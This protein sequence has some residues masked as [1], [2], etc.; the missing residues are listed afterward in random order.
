[1]PTLSIHGEILLEDIDG[2][3]MADLAHLEPFGM[4]NRRPNFVARGV[5]VRKTRIVKGNHLQMTLTGELSFHRLPLVWEID[6]LMWEGSWM[7]YFIPIGTSGTGVELFNKY[8][9]FRVFERRLFWFWHGQWN[10]EYRARGE[11]MV[12]A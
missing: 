9:I 10:V 11:V 4:G 3:Y 6:V 2:R 1:M 7:W 5:Q 8:G 12:S